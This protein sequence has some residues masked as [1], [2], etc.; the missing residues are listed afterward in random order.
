MLMSYRFSLVARQFDV[1]KNCLDLRMLRQALD[2]L[3][4]TLDE[5]HARIL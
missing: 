2:T 3:P 1:L 4:W 5:T